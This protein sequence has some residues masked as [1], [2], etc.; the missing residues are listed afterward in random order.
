MIIVRLIGSLTILLVNMQMSSLVS[1]LHLRYQ[2]IS[3]RMCVRDFTLTDCMAK[4]VYKSEEN[5]YHM[6]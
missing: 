3:V 2:I 4:M 1:F 5:P 6:S